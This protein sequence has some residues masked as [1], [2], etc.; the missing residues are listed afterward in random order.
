MMESEKKATEKPDQTVWIS[1][2]LL[3]TKIV[4]PSGDFEDDV[5][6]PISEKYAQLSQQKIL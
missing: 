6:L 3:E 4:P 2:A 1:D 5:P